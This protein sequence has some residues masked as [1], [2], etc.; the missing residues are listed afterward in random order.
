[1]YQVAAMLDL[2]NNPS[3]LTAPKEEWFWGCGAQDF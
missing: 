3:F 1:M 2:P